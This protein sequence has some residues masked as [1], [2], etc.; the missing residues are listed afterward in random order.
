MCIIF[1]LAVIIFILNTKNWSK[2]DK[3]IIKYLARR[4]E[5][6]LLLLLPA[7]F[8]KSLFHGHAVNATGSMM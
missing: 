2:S 1:I 4:V 5:V 6:I 7:M 8:A 3:C